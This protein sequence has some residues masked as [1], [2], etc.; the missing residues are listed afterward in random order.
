MHYS[1]CLDFV[2]WGSTTT[3]NTELPVELEE[4]EIPNKVDEAAVT[5]IVVS[6]DEGAYSFNVELTSPD[7]GCEQYANWWEGINTD[8][9]L[10]YRRVLRRSHVIEQSF[11][12][13]GAPIEIS[14]DEFI[15]VRG[16]MNTNGYGTIVYA[17]TIDVGLKRDWLEED[18]AKELA[19]DIPQPSACAF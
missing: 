6:G 12:R 16:H 15:Y 11:V 2:F 17:G 14:A 5:D 3:K 4:K 9:K 1:T 18:F 7:K 10:I 13:S 19:V 8:G